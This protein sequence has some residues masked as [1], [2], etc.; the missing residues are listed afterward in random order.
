MGSVVS[1]L[2]SFLFDKMPVRMLDDHDWGAGGYFKMGCEYV[3]IQFIVW[4]Y[5]FMNVRLC[6]V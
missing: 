3:R 4:F 6:L 1:E 5:C 2:A